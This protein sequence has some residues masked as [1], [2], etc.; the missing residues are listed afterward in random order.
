MDNNKIFIKKMIE[1]YGNRTIPKTM[2][3]APK[4]YVGDVKEVYGGH[5]I[6]DIAILDWS[7]DSVWGGIDPSDWFD[8]L[9]KVTRIIKSTLSDVTSINF[10][11]IPL[12]KIK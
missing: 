11:P 3:N 9:F 1:V 10:N 12:E 2:P 5:Y 4:L 8:Q 6:V 7:D